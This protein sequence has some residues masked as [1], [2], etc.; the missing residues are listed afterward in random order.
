MY[1]ASGAPPFVLLCVPPNTVASWA[2]LRISSVV[3]ARYFLGMA[4]VT[5]PVLMTTNRNVNNTMPKRT[6]ITRQ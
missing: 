4:Y 5:K 1:D 6:R 2:G 3:C